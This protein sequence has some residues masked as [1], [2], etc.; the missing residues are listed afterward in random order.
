MTR[1]AFIVFAIILCLYSRHLEARCIAGPTGPTGPTGAT[2]PKGATGTNGTNALSV[3]LPY[4][5]GTGIT[6]NNVNFNLV[7]TIV[8]LDNDAQGINVHL[9]IA[10]SMSSTN[11]PKGNIVLYKTGSATSF[12]SYSATAYTHAVGQNILTVSYL[13]GGS[14]PF[15]SG[16]TIQVL[17]TTTGNVGATGATGATGSVGPTGPTG[18]QNSTF[19]NGINVFGQAFFHN[20]VQVGL[21]INT[22]I[23]DVL[24]NTVFDGSVTFHLPANFVSLQGNQINVGKLVVGI[25]EATQS[26]SLDNGLI[27]TNKFGGLIVQNLTVVKDVLIRGKLNVINA[28]TLDNGAIRTTGAGDL[29][30]NGELLSLGLIQSQGGFVTVGNVQGA[31]GGFSGV[32]SG[33]I[34]IAS[35]PGGSTFDN[36][37]ITTNGVGTLTVKQLFSDNGITTTTLRM[38]STSPHTGD[39]LTSSDNLG[40]AEWKSVDNAIGIS[41]NFTDHSLSSITSPFTKSSFVFGWQKIVQTV[42]LQFPFVNVTGCTAGTV[43]FSGLLPGSLRPISS[44]IQMPIASVLDG[45]LTA[46]SGVI[47]ISTTGI[48]TIGLSPALTSFTGGSSGCGW[49]AFA[50]S[51]LVI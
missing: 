6:L 46:K 49:K 3:S 35:G 32:V 13:S 38:S 10:S 20:Y 44:N 16:D 27:F 11:N 21:S 39:L 7:T 25:L 36:G 34:F 9:F 4:V 1:Y 37:T 17:F 23:L 31:N 18:V 40:N 33:T 24:S 42:V 19:G 41:Q 12:V 29:L 15:S 5:M 2:G 48:V 22:E 26:T 47:E 51:Y 14:V 8:L 43:Q 50:I 45:A 28:T 30:V